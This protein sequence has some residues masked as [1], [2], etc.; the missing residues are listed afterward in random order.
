MSVDSKML[1]L[2]D[3]CNDEIGFIDEYFKK[4]II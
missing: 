3:M 2:D 1:N 4:E